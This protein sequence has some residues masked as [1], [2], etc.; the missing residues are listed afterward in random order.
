MPLSKK[1]KIPK[2]TV[3]VEV[4]IKTQFHL[5]GR[6]GWLVMKKGARISILKEETGNWQFPLYLKFLK[7]HVIFFLMVIGKNN[8]H[9]PSFSQDCS[10]SSVNQGYSTNKNYMMPKEL[11]LQGGQGFSQHGQSKWQGKVE[12]SLLQPEAQTLKALHAYCTQTGLFHP[13]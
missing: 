8:Q 2:S 7:I 11:V 9:S 10:R 12:N 4:T 3:Q 13:K 6:T 1:P 5:W